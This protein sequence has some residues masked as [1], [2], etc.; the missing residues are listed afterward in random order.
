MKFRVSME[1]LILV[2]ICLIDMLSTLFF[3]M[4]GCAVEQNPL[5][6]M[7]LR[8]S[9]AMFVLVK[10]A[11]FIPFVIA[12]ELYRKKDPAFA[13]IVCRSAIVLY[14]VTFTA[15]TLGINLA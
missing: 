3:V 1:S 2:A 15:L 11:S 13:R 6:A 12:I 8:H 7:C 9:P 4:R 14:V 10:I 5:M